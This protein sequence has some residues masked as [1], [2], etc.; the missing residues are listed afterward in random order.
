MILLK[1]ILSLSLSL[2]LNLTNIITLYFF[3]LLYIFF[4]LFFSFSFSIQ[5]KSDA[6]INELQSRVNN[7]EEELRARDAAEAKNST[8]QDETT[9]LK[10]QVG[11]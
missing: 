9:I 10:M 4:L 11:S 3:I 8:P 1:N 2:S 5:V 7:S 6:K